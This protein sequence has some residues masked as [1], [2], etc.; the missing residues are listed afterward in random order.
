MSRVGKILENIMG[1][2]FIV[3]NNWLSK[4]WLFFIYIFTLLVI[5]IAI[6]FAS[7]EALIKQEENNKILK[8]L[9]SEDTSKKAILLKLGKEDNIIKLLKKHDSNLSKP[10]NPP[11]LVKYS[12]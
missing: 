11:I 3:N 10:I 7:K 6:H 9:K 2:E 5:S 8:E 4:Q 12:E 1:G